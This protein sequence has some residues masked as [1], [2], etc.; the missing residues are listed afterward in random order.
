MKLKGILALAGIALSVGASASPTCLIVMPIAD[1]IG[2][3]SALYAPTISGYE[4]RID[5]GYHWSHVL[6]IG[7][8]NTVEI[9]ANNNFQG[10]TQLDV[11]MALAS[12]KNFAVSAGIYNYDVDNKTFDHYVVGRFD[13]SEK[14]IR[15]LKGLRLHAGWLQ[16]DASHLML[17]TDFALPYGMSAMADYVSGNHTYVWTGINI[18]TKIP[19]LVLTPMVGVPNHRDDG[20]QHSLAF[21]YGFKF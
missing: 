8:S 12:G 17:G 18:P 11:K 9:G 7:V 21:N 16:S 15:M 2:Y 4:R 6:T 10:S 3:R 5:K 1:L 19:G 14:D 13:F 20:V